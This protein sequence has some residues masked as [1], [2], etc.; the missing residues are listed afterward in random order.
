M[1]SSSHSWVLHVP[2][3]PYCLN[4]SWREH[5]ARGTSHNSP[6]YDVFWDSCYSFLLRSKYSLWQSV[7]KHCYVLS[8][9]WEMKFHIYMQP[10]TKLQLCI[11]LLL[12]S[13]QEDKIFTTVL[14]STFLEWNLLHKHDSLMLVS[15]P[16]LKVA[17]FWDTGP[18]SQYVNQ[19]FE[20]MYHLQLQDPKSN[21]E[22]TT[23]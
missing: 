8:F 22:E 3:I 9:M 7:L 5:L 4:Q 11:S 18:C 1:H 10:Q 16:T 21:K 2:P 20:E 13:R 15:L 23:V 14:Y 19:C 12:Y 6:H 17:I